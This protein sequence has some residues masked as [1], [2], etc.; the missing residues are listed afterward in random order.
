MFKTSKEVDSEYK[1]VA[2]W[3]DPVWTWRKWY[4]ELKSGDFCYISPQLYRKP[5]SLSSIQYCQR[6]KRKNIIS[7][8]NHF[9]GWLV[10]LYIYGTRRI[11]VAAIIQ[12]M[13]IFSVSVMFDCT[14][15]KHSQKVCRLSH[16]ANVI[17]WDLAEWLE[18]LT[19][20]VKIGMK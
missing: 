9:Q 4:L 15:K 20:N 3:G 5:T 16:R 2:I 6:G 19:A 1:D 10:I 17:G 7:Y 14:W 8:I 12:K 11:F 13:R 18:R